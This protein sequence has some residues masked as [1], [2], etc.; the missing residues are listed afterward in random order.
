MEANDSTTHNAIVS[1]DR[2]SVQRFGRGTAMAQVY[3]H[4][5]LPLCN[6]RD[7]KTEVVWG[8]ADFI[9]RFGRVPEGMWLAE[10]AADIP[11]LE[12]LAAGGIKFTL[13]APRQAKAIRP[14]GWDEWSDIGEEGVDSTLPYLVQLPSGRS[15]VVFFLS[16]IHI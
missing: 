14:I 4:A 5:I 15:I 8:T 3:H 1:A 11:S 13:L 16:L 10:T 6:S 7:K 2:R 9:H 12:A